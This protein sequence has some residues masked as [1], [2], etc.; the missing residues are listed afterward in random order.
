MDTP[1]WLTAARAATGRYL[2][3]NALDPLAHF[4][5]TPPQVAFWS[6]PSSR[7]LLRTGN[8]VGGKTTAACIEGL[9]WCTHTH[10]YRR[11]PAGPVQVWFICVS[12]SQSLAI[13]RK[14]WA[15][16]PKAAIT[17]ET[18]AR[19]TRERGFGANVPC[20]TFL[21]GS[22]IWFRTGKQ[23]PLDQ[24][25]ATLHLVLYDEPPKRQRNFSEL[26]R[27]LTRTGGDM[28]LTMT[29]VNARVDWIREMAESG[30]LTDLHFRCTP[31][32]LRLPNGTIL[33]TEKG[34][35]MDAAWIERERAKVLSFEEPVLIDGEWE[36][37]A[38]GQVFESW[39][40][41]QHM[42][43]G[44]F[45]HPD[46]GVKGKGLRVRLVLG[47]DWGDESLRTA[48]VLCAVQTGDER[49]GIP[50]R[51]WVLGEYVA[52]GPTTVAMDADAVLA[53]L[54]GLG[55]RWSQLAAV[56]GDKKY[57][58]AK[59]RTVKKSNARFE[60]SVAIRLGLAE[61]R[62][63]PRVRSAKRGARRGAGALWLSV[64]WLN[65]RMMTP[66]SFMV[67]KRCEVLSDALSTWD[68]TTMHK[69]KDVI[70]ALRYA[71]VEYWAPTRSGGRVVADRYR[72]Q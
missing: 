14:M 37:R 47:L 30:A 62:T 44:L 57:T 39:D 16:T 3:A 26:E 68:G 27:R 61:G 10:P 23:D 24:A 70:D 41:Q 45:E 55:L 34:D 56:H 49:R 21:D 54:A 15:L 22:Q 43:P 69:A 48:A 53:M 6:S 28:C 8:Q 17:P 66:L 59:G 67:D 72:V 12:W 65:E 4:V 25:G 64:R 29:P 1:S 58:D 40:P 51:V 42:I 18:R 46:V 52:K 7:R 9:W 13:Q 35:L 71:L 32:M 60:S 11:T 33:R 31:E 63:S 36:M 19:Y 50:A 5:G 20:M 2:Q 38:D